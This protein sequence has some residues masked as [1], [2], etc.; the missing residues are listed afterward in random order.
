MSLNMILPFHF[1]GPLFAPMIWK[2]SIFLRSRDQMK[3]D[4]I[5]HKERMGHGPPCTYKYQAILSRGN[6]FD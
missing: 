4:S 3:W 2:R 5:L 6:T 1:Y